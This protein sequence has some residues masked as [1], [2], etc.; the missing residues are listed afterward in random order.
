MATVDKQLNGQDYSN[1]PSWD[2]VDAPTVDDKVTIPNT[3]N[4][5]VVDSGNASDHI[6]LDLLWLHP[7]FTKSFGSQATPIRGSAD[8]IEV[9]GSGGFYYESDAGEGILQ[10]DLIIIDPSNPQA[11]VEI[12]SNAADKGEVLDITALAGNVTLKGNIKF[13]AA[14]SIVRVGRR[15]SPDAQLTVTIGSGLD[16]A[17]PELVIGSG[18]V[19]NSGAVTKVT[20]GG[21]LTQDTAAAAT[22]D[23]LP[24][25]TLIYNHEAT[26]NDVLLVTVYPGAVFDCMQS[27]ENKV[28]DK[29]VALPGSTVLRNAEKHTFT[30]FDD[31]RQ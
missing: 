3:L 23:V 7:L 17:L 8:R 29:V 6:D 2:P 5:D 18:T 15:G 13:A 25:G 12:G 22:I 26:T 9:L 19:F 24:G 10:V 11:I 20:I 16:V 27:P 21:S 28:F 1:G 14:G 30:I 4:A 31:R